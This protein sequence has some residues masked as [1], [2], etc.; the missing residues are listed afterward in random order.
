[1]PASGLGSEERPLLEL[2]GRRE[3]A[4]RFDHDTQQFRQQLE[5][6]RRRKKSEKARPSSAFTNPTAAA[7]EMYKEFMDRMNGAS[8]GRR[9]VKKAKRSA[10]AA[11]SP[12]SGSRPQSRPKSRSRSQLRGRSAPEK[13]QADQELA[14]NMDPVSEK[15]T[16]EMINS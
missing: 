16:Q 7:E 5:A 1:M 3:A 9:T 15:W 10:S 14:S 8:A 2:H 13:P 11:G 12:G 4:L 6:G